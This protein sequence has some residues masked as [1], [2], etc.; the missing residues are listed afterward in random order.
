[1]EPTPGA[2]T[3]AP[4]RPRRTGPTPALWGQGL[5]DADPDFVPA[6]G[7]AEGLTARDA[8]RALRAGEA[9]FR[10]AFDVAPIGMALIVARPDT[11]LRLTRVNRALCQLTGRAEAALVGSDPGDL[12][13]PDE[14]AYT[15]RALQALAD[16]T[17]S[18][19]RGEHRWRCA[20]GSDVWVLVGSGVARDE[21]GT[22]TWILQA[23]DITAR[24]QAEAALVHQARHDQLTGMPNR[25]QLR[26]HLTAALARRHPGGAPR[27]VGI[28]FIDLDNFKEINDA[29]GHAAGD[30]LLVHV[31]RVL[32]ECLDEGDLAAR[33]GG[34]EFVLVCQDVAA[35]RDM[36]SVAGRVHAALG[37]ELQLRDMPVEITAS[38][39]V[40]LSR[41]GDPTPTEL[42]RDADAALY[43]AKAQ[44]RARTEVSD[45][46]LQVRAQR[47]LELAGQLRR[48]VDDGD[49]MLLH[50]QPCW[51]VRTGRLVGV[52]TLIRWDHP[53][54][55]MLTPGEWLD[56]AE[57]RNLI[58]QLGAWVLDAACRQGASWQREFGDDAPQVWVNVSA[59]QLG[60][61]AFAPLVADVLDRTGLRPAGLCLELTERHLLGAAAAGRSDLRAL[62]E[63][64][65]SL[66]VDDFGTGYASMDYLRTIPFDTLKIDAS[67]VAGL[68]VDR[69]DT[70]LT[71]SVITLGHSLGMTV[72]A[73]GVETA[74]QHARLAELGCDIV[75]GYL[76]GRPGPAERISG[77]LTRPTL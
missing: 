61:R 27:R 4:S 74:D 40:A 54:R 43:R 64:G 47:H 2:P 50:F 75:Q 10:L 77:M 73:E 69:T 52:E 72:V 13:H 20:D 28:L 33:V 26:E 57:E 6:E 71:S 18:E 25:A 29:L 21:D 34:D 68:G 30:E 15:L 39:G 24:K 8:E 70:A 44:G 49:Q 46:A 9:R 62:P 31:A 66:A 65:V 35:T 51:E 59:R 60:R 23:E 58:G 17:M 67:Y 36:V 45:P 48:A 1:M 3:T 37:G 11:P 63:L 12:V 38:I 5:W 53:T 76:H 42:L 7:A 55:G 16:G 19:Y 32:G 14:R 56:I 41:G 22:L